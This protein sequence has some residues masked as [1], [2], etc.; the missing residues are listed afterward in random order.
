MLKH[1]WLQT[2]GL[3]WHSSI[4][5]SQRNLLLI[6][7]EC[8]KW[9]DVI[10][11]N[12]PDTENWFSTEMRCIHVT[13]QS[14]QILCRLC[15]RGEMGRSRVP[16]VF[17]KQILYNFTISLFFKRRSHE[18]SSSVFPSSVWRRKK[19]YRRERDIEEK[20]YLDKFFG[21]SWDY[22]PGCTGTY[23]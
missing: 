6:I 8:E 7:N 17:H 5:G 15:N 4:S 16:Y 18:I 10:R 1:L 23:N 14:L 9:T 13:P 20:T 19:T 2:Q 3:A 12:H 22:I 11:P 21:Q